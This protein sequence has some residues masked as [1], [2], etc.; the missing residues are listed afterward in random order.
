MNLEEIKK[1]LE[2]NKENVEV[3]TYLNS[4]KVEPTLEV[5]K[6]KLTNDKDF[7]AFLDSEKDKHL[8]KGIDTFKTN[9]LEKLINE[10]IEKRFPQQ[11][12]KDTEL[13]KLKV[14]IEKMQKESLRKD[15]TNKAIKIATDKKLPIELI[16]YLIGENEESTIE[17][18][19]K[20]ESVF[21][22]SM[23]T[24]VAE[25]LKGNSYTPPN[26]GGGND[27]TTYEDLLKNA[28]NMTSTQIAEAFSKIAK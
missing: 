3:R 19:E 2:E 9:N 17:N 15:L 28:D 20:L 16:D 25:R 7:T 12:P 11:D 13:A 10:E 22:T 18:I 1:W 27:V 23:E 14:E 24:L 26:N 4:F 6:E 8:A 21:N 5:F